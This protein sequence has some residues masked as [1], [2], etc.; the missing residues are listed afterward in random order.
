MKLDFLLCGSPN[1]AFFSQIAFFRRCLDALGGKY[2]R[3]RLVAVFGHETCN[4]LPSRW[5]K[6]FKNIDTVWIMG[7]AY[8]PN[9]YNSQHYSRFD[10]I[11]KDA[12]FAI[13]CDADVALLSPLC[14]LL[15]SLRLNPAL[16]GT[17]AHFPPW[18]DPELAQSSSWDSLSNAVLGK[19]IEKPYKYTLVE[20]GWSPS[21]PFYI[22]YGVLIGTPEL[23]DRFY[24]CEQGL[25]DAVISHTSS[26]WGPQ[27]ALTLACERAQ[28]PTR[29][30]PMRY[31]FPNDGIAD[32]LYQSELENMTFLHY[33][34]SDFFDRHKIFTN[35]SEFAYFLSL[36]LTG[37]NKIMQ[38][39]VINLTEGAYPFK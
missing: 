6:Y 20:P 19:E 30:L 29:A 11:R 15:H 36:E 35:E 25:R 28:I 32:R 23:F 14:D 38:Q 12:D 4:R 34:R 18:H 24:Q 31:N 33:L 8:D 22:N 9:S 27:L 1:D 16:S 3:A 39:H 26:W 5:I 2:E 13:I 37:S 21:T 10:N 17:I 7:D